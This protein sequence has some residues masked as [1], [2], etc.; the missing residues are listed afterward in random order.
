MKAKFINIDPVIRKKTLLS[1]IFFYLF[2]LLS[3][4]A[5]LGPKWGMGY[6]PSEYRRGLDAVFAVD[7]SRSMDI[8]GEIPSSNSR[9]APVSRLERGLAIAK[10]S[11]T[12]V[13]GA[14]FAAAIGRGR[15]YLAVP[16][17][18][19][20]EAAV[21]F[22][23]SIDASSMTGRSTNLE[24]LIEAAA[25]AFQKASPARKV[26]VLVSDGESHSGVIRNAVNRC[27]KE[28]IIIISV[29]AGSDEGVLIQERL[30]D[31][32]SALVFS[33]R[34][35]YIMRGAAER[36]GGIFIDASRE[37]AANV[38]SSH[39]LSLSQETENSGRNKEPKQRRPLFVILALISFG[40]SKFVTRQP[41]KSAMRRI[42]IASLIAVLTLFSSCSEGKLL[43]IEANYLNS[44]GKYDEALIPYMKALDHED[45]APYAEYGLGLT[46]YLLDEGSAALSRYNDSRKLLEKFSENEHRELRFRNHYNTGIIHFEDGEYRMAAEAFKEALKEDP[47]RLEAKRNLEL[48]LML[49]S[50]E[51]NSES[52]SGGQEDLKEILFDYLKQEEIQKWKS[53]EW[54]PPEDN[55]TG[56]DY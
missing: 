45:S 44:R 49:I 47:R 55:Q 3:V 24:S 30:D 19:D 38:L 48:S 13:S 6:A 1:D 5:L 46:F 39:L 15:G 14:R 28:N 42:P 43:L 50:M 17:T 21:V 9:A 23:D 34:D 10:E 31:P 12:S 8:R 56:P 29:A 35:S 40:I 27:V 51:P 2:L 25:N 26:I 16:L 4:I 20:S 7:I 22:L 36:T 37:D 41:G 52:R 53:R 32:D 18:Y 33:K 11:I 54:A